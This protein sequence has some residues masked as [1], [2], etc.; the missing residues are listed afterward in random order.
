MLWT[1]LRDPE[2]IYAVDLG[3]KDTL[4][5]WHV[6]EVPGTRQNPRGLAWDGTYFWLM[7]EPVGASSGRQLF[8]YDL[9]GGRISSYYQY[10]RFH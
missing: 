2:N 1:V 7:A 10:H 5:S 9:G 4:F 3:T 6:P 8:K